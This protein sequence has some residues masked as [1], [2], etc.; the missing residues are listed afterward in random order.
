MNNQDLLLKEIR[1]NL[2]KKQSLNEVISNILDC[3]YDAA[4]RRVSGKAK[5]S[6][7]ETVLLANYFNISMD[8]LFTDNHKVIVE[9][10]IEINSLKDLKTYFQQSALMIEKLTLLPE[11]NLY[12]SA[13]DIPLFYFMD[14][15]I[16][17]KFKAFVWLKVSNTASF[18]HTF[19]EFVI[20]ESFFVEMQKLKKAYQ[21]V[22][23]NEIWNDTT[24][25]SSLQQIQYFFIS[26]LINFQSANL[27]F[28][29][30][31]RIIQILKNKCEITNAKYKLFYNE[32]ILPNNNLLFQNKN[33]MTMLVPYTLLGYFITENHES[34]QNVKNYFDQQLAN[35]IL[36]NAAGLKTQNIFFNKAL[37]KIEY[38]KDLLKTELGFEF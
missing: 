4:H 37:R 21:S 33:K 38:C 22:V 13:K 34:C 28:D 2:Q 23:V 18:E 14:G 8:S 1:R 26:G 3:S 9:K 7:E 12:Y 25:N 35:S 36:L 5:F 20:D 11:T 31:Q 16:L 17:S 24:I 15:T 6:I 29:D 19:E 32:L 30:L 10:T 27:L